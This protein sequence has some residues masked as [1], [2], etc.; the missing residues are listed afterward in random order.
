M[1]EEGDIWEGDKLQRKE[2]AKRLIGY[3][4][5]MATRRSLREDSHGFVLAVDAPYGR[6]KSWFLRRF[7]K[8]MGKNHPVA[9]VDAWTDDLQDE[10]LVALAATLRNA[11]DQ[12]SH[13]SP[14]L[15]ARLAKFVDRAGK[16]AKISA[17][18]AS[19]RALA[20]LITEGAVE[21]IG[22]I[23]DV[24]EDGEKAIGK[25]TDEVIE[26]AIK[27]TPIASVSMEARI[28]EFNQARTEV[29]NMKAAL[30]ELVAGVGE[31][32]GLELPIVIVIDELDRCRPNYAIKLLEEIKHLFDVEGVAF[33]LGMHAGA[34]RHSVAVPYGVNFDGA[35]YLGRFVNQ[36][37]MLKDVPL[38]RI[39]H[40]LIEERGLPIDR[41]RAPQVYQDERG[42]VE[43]H[44]GY[45]IGYYM[46]AAGLGPRHAFPVVDRLENCL[47]LTQ[48][49]P[50]MLPL[51]IPMILADQQGE[52]FEN[53]GPQRLQSWQFV[54]FSNY[55]PGSG[56]V[57]FDEALSRLKKYANIAE[58]NRSSI[59][60]QEDPVGDYFID[61]CRIEPRNLLSN[62]SNYEELLSLVG[63]FK[64]IS[65]A[66]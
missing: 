65:P 64:S 34:L 57:T 29:D 49:A 51:L 62:P 16:V 19:K 31:E 21:A 45:L 24:S 22:A 43:I 37:Y 27:Q 23:G 42:A 44:P 28:D 12:P 47:A 13:Q 15:K 61:F 48:G 25:A 59:M 26:K 3:L 40:D 18:G 6:G 5:T 11:F 32:K 46:H 17:L 20:Y 7:A 9:F 1:S 63:R 55:D 53:W 14:E 60:K 8:E 4:E 54:F 58:I 66:S 33:V 39:L 41:L 50:L 35:A 36:R 52:P 38:H 2:E 30:R 10:P 56:H